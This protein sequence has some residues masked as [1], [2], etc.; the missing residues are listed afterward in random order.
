MAEHNT[1]D[2]VVVYNHHG[3]ILRKLNRPSYEDGNASFI[4][5]VTSGNLNIKERGCDRWI[6]W[7][8]EERA[9]S[10]ESE[11]QD[12]WAVVNTVK[13]R[14]HPANDE[15]LARKI[16][17][18]KL[19]ELKS[20]E[21]RRNNQK[22]FFHLKDGTTYDV[23][24]QHSD[25]Y[26][27]LGSFHNFAILE[28][29]K[30]NRQKYY[31]Q[32]M[33][34][35]ELT[36]SFAEL[37]LFREQGSFVSRFMKDLHDRPFETTLT[38][39]SKITGAVAS[40]LNGSLRNATYRDMPDSDLDI[41]DEH[42]QATPSSVNITGEEY[43]VI[44]TEPFSVLLPLPTRPTVIRGPPLSLDGWMRHVEEDGSISRVDDLL[45]TIF[46]GGVQDELR[47][48]I[49]KYLLGYIPWDLP[50]V[51]AVELRNQKII[52]YH[53]IC[54]QW[55]SMTPGQ[56]DRFGLYRD[57]KS[58]IMKDVNRT[59]RT[60]E[61]F[62]GDDNPHLESLSNILM[63]YMMYNFDLGYMGNFSLEQ[64]SMKEQL[65]HLG[66]LMQVLDPQ[67]ASYL[68]NH[69]SGNL[70]F[71]FRWLLVLFKREFSNKDIMVLWEVLW[72]GHPCQN[73]HLLLC[74][75]IL[76]FERETI[77]SNDNG[78]SDILAHVNS[79]TLHI[80]RDAILCRAEGMFLQLQAVATKLPLA[81]CEILGF[82]PPPVARDSCSEPIERAATPHTT[83]DDDEAFEQALNQNFL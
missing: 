8:P 55:K 45:V 14:S 6:E 56:E 78:L 34:N 21:L 63:S 70:F 44:G 32:G 4:S 80:D 66:C 26:N 65:M 23:I 27:F 19:L 83:S 46:R 15:S 25:V 62:A 58:L 82:P 24:F 72:T 71:C 2:G 59:D 10:V 9:L 48:D 37:D 51:K 42:S 79:L 47:Y 16:V 13:P 38:A 41:S 20:L 77:M 61:Y 7:T 60:L 28:K 31:V 11:S 17:T 5:F 29:S 74:L 67:L 54:Q 1:P 30:R 69:E 52:E 36:R 75:A 68:N 12:E 43:E 3:V 33:V 64:T 76:E 50:Q 53:T 81:V 57:R 18:I 35:T 39:F 40:G 49:W 73:F 22:M